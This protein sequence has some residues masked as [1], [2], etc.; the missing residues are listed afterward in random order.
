VFFPLLSSFEIAGVSE[1]SKFPLLGVWVSSS[2]FAQSGVATRR[3]GDGGPNIVPW[4]LHWNNLDSKLIYRISKKLTVTDF[5]T[6]MNNNDAFPSPQV[7][8]K[9]GLGF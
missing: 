4:L 6:A 3:I 1:D 5:T 9:M 7:R 2:H 8:P